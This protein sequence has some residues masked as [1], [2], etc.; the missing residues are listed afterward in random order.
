MHFLRGIN[1]M[2]SPILSLSI[3]ILFSNEEGWRTINFESSKFSSSMKIFE[4]IIQSEATVA[5]IL[6]LFFLLLNFS[7][8]KA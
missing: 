8:R 5:S 3:K 2:D 4:L 1:L 6:I 7:I